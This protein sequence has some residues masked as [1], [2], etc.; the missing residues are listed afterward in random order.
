MQELL[1]SELLQFLNLKKRKL[2]V[3]RLSAF[4][5]VKPDMSFMKRELKV[6]RWPRTLR[7]SAEPREEDDEVLEK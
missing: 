4:F 6:A 3:S 5:L 7:P 2:K 1:D